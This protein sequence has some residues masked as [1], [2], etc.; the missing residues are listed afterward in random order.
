MNKL[1]KL[2]IINFLFGGTLIAGFAVLSDRFNYG[3]SGN[4]LGAL[5]IIT[6]YMIF[7]AYINN[8][9]SETNSMLW[10][11]VFG[12][13]VYIIFNISFILLYSAFK[14]VFSSYFTALA[15]WVVCQIILIGCILPQ[16]DIEL[17]RKKGE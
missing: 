1:L 8:R 9:Q 14:N 7:H 13:M 3:L 16:F 10:Q 6:T 4:L 5:P 12:A 17:L 15:I 11:A 2:I